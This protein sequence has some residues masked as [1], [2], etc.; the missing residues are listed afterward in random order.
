MTICNRFKTKESLLKAALAVMLEENPVDVVEG[1]P[2]HESLLRVARHNRAMALAHPRAFPLFVMVPPFESPVREYTERVF[3]T[4]AGQGIPEDLPYAFLSIM[5]SFLS[6]FQM[7]ES[8]T[9]TA[10]EQAQ[11]APEAVES[12]RIFGEES[13]ERDLQVI[14]SGLAQVYGLPLSR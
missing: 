11:P 2:W 13:F 6:G 5:H 14:L 1:E 9:L 3:A 4:H 7:A 8:F 10:L 12:A